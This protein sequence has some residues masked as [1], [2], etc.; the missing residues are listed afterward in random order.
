MEYTMS[1]TNMINKINIHIQEA[2]HRKIIKL[3]T[4]RRCVTNDQLILVN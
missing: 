3:M 2:K 4:K 1:S